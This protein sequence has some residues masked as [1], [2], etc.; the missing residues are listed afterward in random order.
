MKFLVGEKHYGISRLSTLMPSRMFSFSRWSPV[1]LR[2][3]VFDML[4]PTFG[5]SFVINMRVYVFGPPHAEHPRFQ[6][7]FKLSKKVFHLNKRFDPPWR[8]RKGAA[9]TPAPYCNTRFA[10]NLSSPSFSQHT[11]GRGRL[12]TAAVEVFVLEGLSRTEIWSTMGIFGGFWQ[13]I[14]ARG[15]P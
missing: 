1:T 3:G 11:K 15:Q 5:A 2:R 7:P 4:C 14:S 9:Q 8:L 12:S 10:P 6:F 13:C